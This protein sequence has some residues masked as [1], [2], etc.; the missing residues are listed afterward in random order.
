MA[1]IGK[2]PADIALTASDITDGIISTAKIADN[3]VTEPKTAWNDVPLRNIV[4]N[5]DMQV[6]QRTTGTTGLTSGSNFVV[7]RTM[8]QIGTAGT[9]TVSQDTDVPTGEGFAKSLKLDCTT[10]NGSLSAGSYGILVQRI[11]GLNLQHIKKGTANAE[12]LTLSFWIKTNLN[13]TYQVN[14]LDSDNTRIIGKTYTIS[15][16]DTWE[17]KE[18]TFAGDT[19]GALG[20]DTGN[21]LQIEF[22]F[23]AGSTYSGGA[24]PTSWEATATTDRCATSVNLSSSTSNYLNI[25]GLQL[26]VG[27]TASNFEFL[28]YDVNLQRCFRYFENIA[29]NNTIVGMGGSYATDFCGCYRYCTPKRGNPSIY[30]V[31]GTNYFRIYNGATVSFDSFTIAYA[32]QNGCLFYAQPTITDNLI[33][34]F[35]C[36]NSSAKIALEAEL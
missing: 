27:T 12:D 14:L 23:I 1:Y 17:Q 3:A 11:E 20:N 7:D 30:Q 33:G 22:W 28:P 29:A 36:Y 10:A 21:A 13:G 18:I 19:T 16:A 2:Q 26:E 6:A 31:S 5:G 8:W 32:S 9:W 4:I 34:W 25:T 15:S 35:T 24:V